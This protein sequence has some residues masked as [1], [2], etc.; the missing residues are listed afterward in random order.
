MNI[1]LYARALRNKLAVE[2]LQNIMNYL[3]QNG[4]G[5]YFHE[6]LHKNIIESKLAFENKYE[7][8]STDEIK[9]SKIE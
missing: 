5:I 2:C 8:F 9:Q 4:I 7:V 6:D 1:G 3:G